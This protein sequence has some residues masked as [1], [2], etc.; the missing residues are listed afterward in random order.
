MNE[1]EEDV[2]MDGVSDSLD[3]QDGLNEE[4]ED[5]QEE[6]AFE[7]PGHLGTEHELTRD[8]LPVRT[9]V[10]YICSKI[11]NSSVL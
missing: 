4:D 3:V 6:E 10:V 1:E 9:G 11:P 2:A 7:N 5:E 8:I